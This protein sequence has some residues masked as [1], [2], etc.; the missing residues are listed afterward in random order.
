MITITPSLTL[1]ALAIL[2]I[3]HPTSTLILFLPIYIILVAHY[4]FPTYILMTLTPTTILFLL[5]TLILFPL[6]YLT[7]VTHHT[8][9]P[10]FLMILTPTPLDKIT[11]FLIN[12]HIIFSLTLTLVHTLSSNYLYFTT[13]SILPTYILITTS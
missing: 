12:L 5:P 4:I 3:L 8:F 7:L 11:I 13:N 9:L 2:T 10:Y 6:T 1:S